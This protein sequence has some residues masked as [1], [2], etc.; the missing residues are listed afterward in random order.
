[1]LI[2]GDVTNYKC[3]HCNTIYAIDN[4]KKVLYRKISL[5][6]HDREKDIIMIKCRQ[7]KNMI[8]VKK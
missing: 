2:E 6:I 3:P 1:M 4:G 7:C 8:T 5:Y